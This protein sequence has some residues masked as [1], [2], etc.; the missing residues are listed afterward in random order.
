VLLH[1]LCV[2]GERT[3]VGSCL[4]SLYGWLDL[5]MI[6]CQYE[7]GWIFFGGILETQHEL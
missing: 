5:I 6:P 4:I 2:T 7:H 1:Y 3:K